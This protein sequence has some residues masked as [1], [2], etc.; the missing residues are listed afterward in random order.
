MKRTKLGKQRFLFKTIAVGNIC[1]SELHLAETVGG[2][3]FHCGLGWASRKVVEDDRQQVDQWDV[4]NTVSYFFSLLMFSSVMRPS[5]FASWY[6]PTET[7]RYR[8]MD[9]IFL[10][11]CILGDAPRSSNKILLGTKTDKRVLKRFTYI[12]KE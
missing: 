5:V 9:V 7:G 11:D 1:T 3:V 12:S 6:L 4:W 8:C 2:K 10:G